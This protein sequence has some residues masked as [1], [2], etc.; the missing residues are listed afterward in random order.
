LPILAAASIPN[1]VKHSLY[2][3]RVNQSANRSVLARDLLP[4][5]K[6]TKTIMTGF[7]KILKVNLLGLEAEQ[8]R[9]SRKILL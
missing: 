6:T 4:V 2:H 3:Y 5:V 7:H 8:T 9:M 1:K